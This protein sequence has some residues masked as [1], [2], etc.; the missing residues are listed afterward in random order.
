MRKF[1][2][3]L[4]FGGTFLISFQSFNEQRETLQKDQLE[5]VMRRIGHEVLLSLNESL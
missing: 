4:I 3:F 1:L 2:L 5:V